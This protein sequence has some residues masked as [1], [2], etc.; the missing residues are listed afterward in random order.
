MVIGGYS[1][2]HVLNTPTYDLDLL[3]FGFTIGFNSMDFNIHNSKWM[4]Q[5]DTVYS[6]NSVRQLGFNIGIVSNL[7]LAKY[8]D[9]R[10][11]PGIM[12]GQRNMDYLIWMNNKFQDKLMK[13]ES[14]FLDFPLT[15]KYKAKRI[16]NYRPYLL[17]GF[18]YRVDLASQK[19][20]KEEEKPKIRLE[21]NDFYYELGFG[22]D[23]YLAYFKFST[24]LKYSIGMRNIIKPDNTEYTK[25]IENLG[26]EILV[27][28]FHFE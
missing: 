24:E 26:S 1:Q 21:K 18:S 19:A 17:A 4:Y 9:L 8:L 27:I 3:H 2:S 13:I 14:T 15:L 11:L 16:E 12:F 5:L 10:F 22:V 28:S 7:R 25:S 20:I 23:Y 6:V